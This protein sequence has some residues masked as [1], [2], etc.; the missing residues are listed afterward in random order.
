MNLLDLVIQVSIM[1]AVY[2]VFFAPKQNSVNIYNERL[3]HCC[4]QLWQ[5]EEL[6]EDTEPTVPK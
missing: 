4:P 2:H 3:C 1:I 6:S 5:T